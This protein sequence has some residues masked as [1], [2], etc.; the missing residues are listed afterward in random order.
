MSDA[1]LVVQK[2]IFDAVSAAVSP[3]PVFD[4]IPQDQPPP[5]VTVG[6]DTISYDDSKTS[7]GQEHSITIQVFSGRRGRVEAKT[8]MAQVYAALHQ[9]RLV[10]SGQTATP[11]K[12]E[13]GDSFMEPD[14]VHARVV[15]RYR[16]KT[17]P[18]I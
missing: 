17:Q 4:H 12:F 18:S 11:V 15:H 8:L 13:F 10:I 1:S 2:A 14:G 3:A 9:Q 5:Y 16:L 6:D 7:F